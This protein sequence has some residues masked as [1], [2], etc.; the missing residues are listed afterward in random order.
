MGCLNPIQSYKKSHMERHYEQDEA[1]DNDLQH[2]LHSFGVFWDRYGN[3]ILVVVSLAAITFAGWSWW[4]RSQIEAREQALSQ[5]ATA[6]SPE[7]MIGLGDD[8]I[9]SRPG[10]ALTSYLH[11]GDLS[12][13]EV[14]D[15]TKT[16]EERARALANAK[17]AFDK[18]LA[19][20]AD[21]P[22][23][24]VNALLGAAA[25][26]E[27]ERDFDK[28][29]SHYEE[30]LSLAEASSLGLHAAKAQA[31]LDLLP[32]LSQPVTLLPDPGPAA[33]A[34]GAGGLAPLN[35]PALDLPA[36]DLPAIELPDLSPTQEPETSPQP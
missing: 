17:S 25:V 33:G 3:S 29:K 32:E 23:F 6:T 36:I 14:I 27:N 31:R 21:Q 34:E 2:F 15:L 28:A 9:T 7:A 16:E 24:R 1:A 4:R 11:A 22:I 18:A 12:L 35:M 8:Y 30:V 20:S 5:L 26:A 19:A 10:V 13:F